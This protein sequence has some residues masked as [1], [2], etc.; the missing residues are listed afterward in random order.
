MKGFDKI[1]FIKNIGSSWLGLVVNIAT[2]IVIS[3]YILHKLGDEA[4]GLWVLV[5]SINGYYGLFDMGIRSSI[6]RYVAKYSATDEH[7]ELNRVISTS[8]FSY[9][10]VFLILLALTGAG[11]FY[12]DRIVHIQP[13]YV[14]TGKL[15][16]LMVGASLALGFPLGVFAGVLEGLQKFYL[17]N[18]INITTTILRAV[19]IVVALG[20]GFG[21]LMVTWIT[22]LLPLVNQL[23]NAFN[24][25]RLT[26]VRIGLRF[27]TKEM[28]KRLFS[29]GSV[30]FMFT[31]ARNL[32]F[33]TDS[34]VIGAFL[35]AAAITPFAIASRIVDYSTS[36]VDTLAQVFTPMSSHFDAKGEIDKLRAVFVQGNRACGLIVFPICAGVIILGKAIIQVWMGAKYIPASYPVLLILII[37]ATLRMAQATSPR[38]LFGMARHKT[39]AF[40]VVLEG[41]VNL[42]LSI[43]LVRH[44][45]IV[46]DALGTAIPLMFTCLFFLPQHLCGILGMKVRTFLTKA[47]L[48]PALLCVPMI[49]VLLVLG[50]WSYPHKLWQLGLHTAAGGLVYTA[51]AYYFMFVKGPY[52]RRKQL[53][54]P[55]RPRP[56]VPE[57]PA[58][59]E[60]AAEVSEGTAE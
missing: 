51:F 9:S 33:K 20:H 42:L 48:I 21:L 52:G 26:H 54:P 39:M 2:G 18:S 25:F 17:I 38:I 57:P 36:M 47:Y 53:L 11:S 32:R 5:F 22:I 27:V 29:Y 28:F 3:P 37:P 55:S 46:G 14:V 4:F 41:V 10:A 58:I 23:A 56:L 19:L 24:V 50:R 43:A 16:F 15:L 7:D 44:Y 31:V 30:T 59:V 60:Y 45:G 49:A 13:A 8:L 35:S 1:A 6:V 40:V 34:L 12:L